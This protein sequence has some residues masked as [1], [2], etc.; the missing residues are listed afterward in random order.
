[1]GGRAVTET[2]DPLFLSLVEQL[3]LLRSKRLKSH[4]LTAKYVERIRKLNPRLNIVV[5]DNF[6][7][8]LKR[9]RELDEEL[10]TT[11]AP[12][13]PLHGIPFT[14]KDAFRIKH[15]HTSYGFPT[16]NYLPSFDNCAIVERLV[17]AGAVLLGQTNVPLS[18]FD[19]QT[20]SPIYGLT[21]N[22][23]IKNE[24]LAAPLVDRRLVSLHI[25]RL[26]RWEVTLLVQFVIQP[27]VAESLVCDR[28]TILFPSY[29]VGPI[30]HKASF[31]NLAVAGP[32]A[33][34]LNDLKVVLKVLT[35]TAEQ[36]ETREKL[37]IAY[38]LEWSGV[39]VDDQSQRRIMDFIRSVI[40][41]GHEVVEIQAPVDF[42]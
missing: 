24:L 39:R 27:I 26:S 6:A 9:A 17:S 40:A 8:A 23:L 36:T 34:T 2:V 21:R 22:P 29:D 3:E 4:D 38:T 30:L 42:D 33:R 7:N 25:F 12:V 28:R 41:L 11:G 16:F 15:L 37:R 19:W 5:R 10:E 31:S 35:K 13:G 18:C 20:N 14:I 32:L 1:M